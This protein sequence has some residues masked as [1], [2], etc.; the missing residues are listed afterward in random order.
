MDTNLIKLRNLDNELATSILSDFIYLPAAVTREFLIA[1]T[2]FVSRRKKIKSHKHRN[3]CEVS[4]T[5][6][7]HVILS[8]FDL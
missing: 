1:R 4:Q 5:Y 7:G 2:T 8:D 6:A 3:L